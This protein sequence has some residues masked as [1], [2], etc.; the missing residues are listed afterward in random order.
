MSC[1]PSR[2][3]VFIMQTI[4]PTTDAAGLDAIV[5]QVVKSTKKFTEEER[6][7][8]PS[9][10]NVIRAII[11]V[12]FSD[13]DKH[14]GLYVGDAALIFINNLTNSSCTSMSITLTPCPYG[15]ITSGCTPMST[16]LWHCSPFCFK[17]TQH[18]DLR[19]ILRPAPWVLGAKHASI[20][21]RL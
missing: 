5:G 2:V 7:K 11:D 15:P 18:L 10:F 14:L 8:Q 3:F 17:W 21:P 9:I 13:K 19:C 1:R 16:T 4:T 20:R 12:F 6:S